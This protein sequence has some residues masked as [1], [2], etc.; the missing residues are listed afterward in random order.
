MD[1]AKF[2]QWRATG[3]TSLRN[4]LVMENMGIVYKV[5]RSAAPGPDFLDLVQSGTIGLMV[6]LDR[7]DPTQGAFITFA[8]WHVLHE[9]QKAIRKGKGHF[10][11]TATERQTPDLLRDLLGWDE[12]ETDGGI[13]ERETKLDLDRALKGTSAVERG[14]LLGAVERETTAEASARLG[15]VK[16]NPHLTGAVVVVAMGKARRNLKGEL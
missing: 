9:V 8:K 13:A 6:A 10:S 4:A 11:D 7:F 1:L 3:L 14:A 2:A 5:V 12:S 16:P 15:L